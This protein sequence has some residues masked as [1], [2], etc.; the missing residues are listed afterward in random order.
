MH[1]LHYE[2]STVIPTPATK[3]TSFEMLPPITLNQPNSSKKIY[4]F[5]HTTDTLNRVAKQTSDLHF[6]WSDSFLPDHANLFRNMPPGYVVVLELPQEET[7]KE[8]GAEQF[9][10]AFIELRRIAN[11]PTILCLG[12]NVPANLVVDWMR[13]GLYAY[14]ESTGSS[15]SLLKLIQEATADAARARQ[16]YDRFMELNLLWGDINPR[17]S[18]VLEMVMS[19]VPN[20]TIAARL[21]VSQRT[22]EAR[23]QKLYQK[24]QSKSLPGVVVKLCEWRQLR[25]DFAELPLVKTNLNHLNFTLSDSPE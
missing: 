9:P 25:A 3:F 13:N 18:E 14:G 19:G 20:K 2:P 15:A 10:K 16:R 23:R 7:Q 22:I 1:S 11:L 21:N 4:W 17:E 12:M 24:L 6:E 8:P 5:S